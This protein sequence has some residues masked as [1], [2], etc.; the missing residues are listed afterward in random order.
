M[1]TALGPYLATSLAPSTTDV[2]TTV[3][4]HTTACDSSSFLTPS[5]PEAFFFLNSLVVSLTSH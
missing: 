2:S 4:F 1:L 5:F 3:V